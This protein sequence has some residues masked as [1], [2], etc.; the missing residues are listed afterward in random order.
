[1]LSTQPRN[2]NWKWISRDVHFRFY[3][4]LARFV[5]WFFF[6]FRPKVRRKNQNKREDISKEKLCAI[7][8]SCFS[9]VAF[10]SWASGRNE[11]SPPDQTRNGER[12]GTVWRWIISCSH[13]TFRNFSVQLFM[14]WERKS[15]A[16]VDWLIHFNVYEVGEKAERRTKQNTNKQSTWIPWNNKKQSEN[17]KTNMERKEIN[18]TNQKLSSIS[19]IKIMDLCVFIATSHHLIL[20]SHSTWRLL[21]KFSFLSR[22]AIAWGT[23]EQ[24]SSDS[25]SSVTNGLA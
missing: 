14:Q 15:R 2:S 16:W 20:P 9:F 22:E 21:M 11:N 18:F 1:M 10:E 6:S 7:V 8:V 19:S 24:I 5:F 3:L 12:W 17:D 23:L 13:N 4:R 25:R